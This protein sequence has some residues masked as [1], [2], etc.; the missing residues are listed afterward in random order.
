MRRASQKQFSV[1]VQCERVPHIGLVPASLES[2]RPCH[3]HH[4]WDNVSYPADYGWFECKCHNQI[5]EAQST[6]FLDSRRNDHKCNNPDQR[7]PKGLL[8]STWL[9]N[10][11][12]CRQTTHLNPKALSQC[13]S[14][15]HAWHL[16][17]LYDTLL[18]QMLDT[19]DQYHHQGVSVGNHSC[20]LSSPRQDI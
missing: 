7:H 4:D 12:G 9:R 15:L 6:D 14:A 16:A 1:G 2:E 3:S 8:Q 5:V 20:C 10:T 11:F 18:L 17:Q 19:T 13:A